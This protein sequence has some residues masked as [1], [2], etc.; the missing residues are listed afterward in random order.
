MPWFVPGGIITLRTSI[1]RLGGISVSFILYYSRTSVAPT[2]MARLQQLFS[3]NW[4]LSKKKK[5]NIAA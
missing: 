4:F 5:K 3:S 2:L 1:R